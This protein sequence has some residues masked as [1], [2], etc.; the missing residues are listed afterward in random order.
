VEKDISRATLRDGVCGKEPPLED[1]AGNTKTDT[2][3]QFRG[4]LLPPV[5]CCSMRNKRMGDTFPTKGP[6]D[7]A[8]RGAF[9]VTDCPISWKAR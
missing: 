7:P 4:A 9:G 2:F 3:Q 1:G 8:K 6:S 5:Y